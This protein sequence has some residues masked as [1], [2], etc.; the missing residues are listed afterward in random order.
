MEEQIEKAKRQKRSA[1]IIIVALVVIMVAAFGAY[2]FLAPSMRSQD[3][4]QSGG[5]TLST[6]SAAS[7][8]SARGAL[9]VEVLSSNDESMSLAQIAQGKP[10]VVN[11]WATWCPY[12]VAEMNDYQRLYEEFGDK[13]SFVMLNACDSTQEVA[14]AHEYI[15]ENGFTFP[16]YYDN[17]H[18]GVAEF[19]VRAYPT[20]VIIAADG[21]VLMNRA[22]QVNYEGMASALANL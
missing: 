9:D 8:S 12:C 17:A 7:S 1:G 15:A 21:T 6:S 11:F 14:L 19:G 2:S 13:V 22:G 20:T 3:S 16:V 10:T 4:A 5:Y 18:Q